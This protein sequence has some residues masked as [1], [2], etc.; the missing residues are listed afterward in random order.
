MLSVIESELRREA[1]CLLCV[2]H[3]PEEAERAS[4]SVLQMESG[5]IPEHG[6][7]S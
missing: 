1:A 6:H 2:T 3:D 7:V 5:R 4:M